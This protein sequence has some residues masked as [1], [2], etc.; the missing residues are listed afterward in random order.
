[1]EGGREMTET[2]HK[3]L[4]P[5]FALREL[6]DDLE[7]ARRL[8]DADEGPMRMYYLGKYDALALAV[9]ILEEVAGCG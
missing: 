5:A 3:G 8:A 6:R 9:R 7:R 1:M 4:D 2:A